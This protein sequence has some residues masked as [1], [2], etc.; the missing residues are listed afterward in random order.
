MD[1]QPCQPRPHM[2]GRSEGSLDAGY[3]PANR[4]AN[5]GK[6]WQKSENRFVRRIVPN[7][8]RCP[9]GKRGMSHQLTNG[10]SL[11]EEAGLDLD[12]RLAEQ[13]FDVAW[14]R[15]GDSGNFALEEGFLLRGEPIMES[16]GMRL[17]LD[18]H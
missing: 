3:V 15:R 12:D 7:E 1:E 16:D 14:V 8:Q 5:P 11:A 4:I 10:R 17:V 9:P 18:D 13:D 6:L 2:L